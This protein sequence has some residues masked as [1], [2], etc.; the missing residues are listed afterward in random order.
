MCSKEK[1]LAVIEK[2]YIITT[3]ISNVTPVLISSGS[4]DGKTDVLVVKDGNGNPIVPGTSLA[5]VLRTQIKSIYNEDVEKLVFGNISAKAKERNQSMLSISDIVLKGVQGEQAEIVCRDCVRIDPFAAST[6]KGGKFDFEAVERGASGK[7][8]LELTVR[9]ELAIRA[10]ELC[11]K[12]TLVHSIYKEE[13]D[14]FA[15]VMA[16]IADMLTYGV[17]VGAKTASGLGKLKTVQ[18]AQVVEFDFRNSRDAYKWLQYLK[19][20]SK[21]P[22]A[23]YNSPKNASKIVPDGDLQIALLASINSALLVKDQDTDEKDGDTAISAVQMKSKDSFLIPGTSI[24]GVIRHESYNI[25]RN[26]FH[27]DELRIK[28]F[29]TELMGNVETRSGDDNTLGQA[30]RLSVDEVYIAPEDVDNSINQKRIRINRFTRSVMPGALFTEQPIWQTNGNLTP[31]N[32]NIYVKHCSEKEAGLVLLVLR[33]I[34]LGR[35]SIGSGKGIGRGYI[36]GRY[37]ELIYKN[38]DNE[39]RFV[40]DATDKLEVTGDKAVLE[41]YVKKLVGEDNDKD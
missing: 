15:D 1:P 12:V 36:T 37:A 2:K 34:F 4:T 22:Q 41:S 5:G 13:K 6:E 9:K 19:D 31:V 21:L 8:F 25:L 27:G 40:L 23:L 17:Q 7:L 26:V 14:L 35:L 29:I 33:S 3:D 10:N 28:N 24:R 11:E 32:I 39:T 20:R 38:G 16:T 18:P 30:S